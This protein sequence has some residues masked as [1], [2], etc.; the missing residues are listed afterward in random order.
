MEAFFVLGNIFISLK[1]IVSCDECD[2]DEGLTR[3]VIY[4]IGMLTPK[5]YNI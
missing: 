2:E 4:K 3:T 5:F 1:S